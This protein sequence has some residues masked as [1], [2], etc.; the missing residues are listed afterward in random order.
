MPDD[1]P[2]RKIIHVDMDA[3]YASVAQMD[4]PELKGKPIAVGGGGTRG[5]ISAASYEARKF[6]VKSA[7]T[8]RLAIKL[9]PDLIFV[10]TDFERY[11]TIS[12]QVRA[13]FH[14]YTD[15]VEPLSLD[16]A[17]LDVTENKKG[18][19]SATLIAEEIRNR[20]QNEIGLTASAGISINK[21]IAKVA[22]DYNKPN[23]QKTVNPEDVVQFLEAL[24]I[25]KFY[26]VGK[27]TAEKMYQLGIFTGK[28]LKSKSLDYLELN[29]GKSGKFY[30]DVVRGI[31]RSEVK[32]NRIRK[33]L[34]AERTFSENLSSEIFMLEKLEHIADEVARRLQQSKVAGK[35]VTLK[36]KYSDF[37][38]QTRSKT[39]E[40]F[41]SDKSMILEIAKQLLYQEKLKNSVRLL[42]ISLSNLNTEKSTENIEQRAKES[43]SV[44]LKFEF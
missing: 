36:I 8:G 7:M 25:R 4:N 30:F 33:S 29:F 19:P 1:L 14:D 11:K 12:K 6:G 40:Y 42:G 13:I 17:Y 18:N 16:E 26:G 44:Q 31:H 15:L 9:C 39:S 28:D 27:V 22:S 2:I 34:A 38:L 24:D 32:P 37:T 43:V 5:V 35:T 21:F 20:I 10:K 41:M 3:F 23:G